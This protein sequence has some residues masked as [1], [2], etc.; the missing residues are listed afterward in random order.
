MNNMLAGVG[1]LAGLGDA[2]H[3]K[4]WLAVVAVF[5]GAVVALVMLHRRAGAQVELE[6]AEQILREHDVLD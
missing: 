4:L 6:H 1:T 3:A 2:H 5:V